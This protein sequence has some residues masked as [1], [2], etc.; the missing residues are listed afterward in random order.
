M[1][2][3]VDILERGLESVGVWFLVGFLFLENIP[4]VGLFAPGLTVLV[5]SGFFHELFGL[6]ILALYLIAVATI[7]LA[8]TTWFTIGYLGQKQTA[9]LGRLAQQSPNVEEVLRTQSF[10]TLVFYQFIPYFRMFF[11]FAL[12]LYRYSLL[13]WLVICSI[14]SLLYTAVF[15]GLGVGGAYVLQQVG[16]VDDLTNLLNAV[17]VVCGLAYVYRLLRQYRNLQRTNKQDEQENAS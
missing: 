1:E 4:I 12:G 10:S 8:D 16:A 3:Y 15:F 7:I 9:W 6:S 5:L 2:A 11:P 17:L 14:G 13:R